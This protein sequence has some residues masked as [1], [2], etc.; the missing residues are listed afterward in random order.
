[1]WCSPPQRA[2]GGA[3]A[4]LPVAR[5]PPPPPS[6]HPEENPAQQERHP[7]ARAMA[8]VGQQ[9]AV[10]D[11]GSGASMP[12]NQSGNGPAYGKQ[13]IAPIFFSLKK[14]QMLA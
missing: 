3:G 10:N 7:N 5:E 4:A 14:R 2:H 6:A 9:D 13:A 8:S 1:M 11:Q 12:Y